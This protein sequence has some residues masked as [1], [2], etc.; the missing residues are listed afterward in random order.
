MS[1]DKATVHLV[2]LASDILQRVG[3]LVSHQE[4]DLVVLVEEVVVKD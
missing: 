1:A 3:L 2:Q 4:S